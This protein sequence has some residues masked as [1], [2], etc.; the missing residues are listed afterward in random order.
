MQQGL[1]PGHRAIPVNTPPVHPIL[2]T[3]LVD[4]KKEDTDQ[5]SRGLSIRV[6]VFEEGIGGI[7]GRRS[8]SAGLLLA[9]LRR[10]Q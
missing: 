2:E 7:H 4:A 10:Y 5:C 3:L 6:G 9:L 1:P 8:I